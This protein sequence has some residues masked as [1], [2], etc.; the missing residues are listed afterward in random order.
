MIEAAEREGLITPG[1]TTIVEPTS[2]NTGIALCF[3]AA[4]KGYR[5]VIVMPDTY[6]PERRVI[7]R[8]FGARLVITDGSKGMKGAIDKAH[9][10]CG[11]I[12]DCYMPQQFVNPANPD[13][14]FAT[15]A[16]EI[17]EATEGEVDALVAGVG[18][19]GTIT[20]VGRYIKA[21]KPSF[22]CIAVE[23]EDSQVLSGGPPGAHKIQGIGAGFVPEV[24]DQDMLDQ[25]IAI[26]NDEAIETALRLAREEGILGGYSA[27][28]NVAAGLK[29]A[30]QGGNA[31]KLI[32]V[33]IPDFGER[34]VQTSLFERLRYDGSDK[35][36][37]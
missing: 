12:P 1:K 21:K 6:S 15:T 31:G 34:Y 4:V 18:T 35:V 37:P 7:M 26:S 23:P 11:S 22:E 5:C 25:V 10:L 32:V 27:G 36:E 13:I 9:E 28:A 16:P 30:A 20:G 2:G 3:V 8:G 17:W 24:L 19:G 29:Y 33:I 14:H